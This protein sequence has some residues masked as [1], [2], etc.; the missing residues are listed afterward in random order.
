MAGRREGQ[1]KEGASSG[2]SRWAGAG[3]GQVDGCPLWRLEGPGCTSVGVAFYSQLQAIA[4][5]NCS[6]GRG[7]GDRRRW[8]AWEMYRWG[9]AAG[10]RYSGDASRPNALMACYCIFAQKLLA[11]V[12]LT[13]KVPVLLDHEGGHLHGL[14]GAERWSGG[15]QAGSAEHIQHITVRLRFQAAR[16]WECETSC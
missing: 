16:Q 11:K 5:L 7:R 10:R 4:S 14:E 12:R 9:A 1:R 2:G 6:T 3:A 8:S 15:G 13:V